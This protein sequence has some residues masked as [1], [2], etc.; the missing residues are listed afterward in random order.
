MERRVVSVHSQQMKYH[1]RL[2]LSLCLSVCLFACVFL[3]FSTSSEQRKS[4]IVF[5]GRDLPKERIKST[6][7]DCIALEEDIPSQ[8]GVWLE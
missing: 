2:F 3:C 1:I 5:I 7:R 4:K 6:F 8:P